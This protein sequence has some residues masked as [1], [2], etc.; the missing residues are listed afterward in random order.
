MSSD[1][2]F[3]SL[4][5]V[6]EP[7]VRHRRRIVRRRRPNFFEILNDEQFKQRFRF[8][9][10]VHILFN[11]IKKL[12]PQRIKRV[13]CISP[14]LHLLIALRFYATGSFQAVVGD[15]ANVSKTTVCRVTDR[16]SRAIA[17]LRP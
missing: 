13:D 1:S 6:S 10:E 2:S 9:K 4:G 16:V 14:M 8:T 7:V 11:K 12:L 17:T 3:S 5:E 15:T